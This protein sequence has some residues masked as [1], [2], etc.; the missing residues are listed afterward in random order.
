MNGPQCFAASINQIQAK[1]SD[2][3]YMQIAIDLAKS[4]HSAVTF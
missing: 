1:K 4:R 3:Y 2:E